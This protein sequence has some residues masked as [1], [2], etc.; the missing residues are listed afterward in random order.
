[1]L[2]Q[3]DLKMLKMFLGFRK[4]LENPFTHR[5]P[6]CHLVEYNQVPIMVYGKRQYKPGDVIF[7]P[8]I[9]ET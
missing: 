5:L 8:E 7:Y 6:W 1:M 3:R 2:H 4:S 9:T